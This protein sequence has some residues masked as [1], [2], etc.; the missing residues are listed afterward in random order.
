MKAHMEAMVKT[1][2]P[3]QTSAIVR[4]PAAR[5]VRRRSKPIIDPIPSDATT[6]TFMSASHLLMPRRMA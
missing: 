4:I 1:H 2:A 3:R 5:S 6:L